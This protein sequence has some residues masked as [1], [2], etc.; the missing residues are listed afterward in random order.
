MGNTSVVFSSLHPLKG[1]SLR[2]TRGGS[3]SQLRH[4]DWSRANP[5]WEGRAMVHGR[6]SKATTNV[7]LTASLIKKKLGVPLSTAERELEHRFPQK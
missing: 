3:L 6:I 5:E 2:E 4:V 1:W 7:A